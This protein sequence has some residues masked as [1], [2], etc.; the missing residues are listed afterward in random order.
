MR[1]I[2][3]DIVLRSVNWV[4]GRTGNEATQGPLTH[5]KGGMSSVCAIEWAIGTP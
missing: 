3:A 5:I 2:A 1:D 4:Q